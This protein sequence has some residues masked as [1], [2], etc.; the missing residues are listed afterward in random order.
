HFQFGGTFG[1]MAVGLA[2]PT[3]GPWLKRSQSISARRSVGR[4]MPNR[5]HLRARRSPDA[6]SVPVGANRTGLVASAPRALA[7]LI[8]TLAGMTL[9][10]ARVPS[11]HPFRE[12]FTESRV[13]T[14]Q[15]HLYDGYYARL[16]AEAQSAVRRET[17]DE[18]VGQASWITLAEA[19]DWFG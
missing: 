12:P 11:A 14:E 1:D 4:R 19:R 8:L 16:A 5:P 9:A 17:W 7:T 18:D 15:F 2:T 3:R 6:V 10:R 13:T